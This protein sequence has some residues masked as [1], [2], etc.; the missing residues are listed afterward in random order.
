MSW[1][2]VLDVVAWLC[3]LGGSLLAFSAG[4]GVVRFPDLL[5]RMHTAA[6]PQVLGL[7]LLMLGLGLR[8]R[9][10]HIIWMLVLVVLFQMLTAPVA[11]HM[12]SRAGYRTGKVRSEMLVVDELTRDMEAAQA[13]ASR[14]EQQDEREGG[15][16]VSG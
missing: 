16:A 7:L 2:T 6:K 5:A 8:L 15:P 14:E 9:T 4:V 11:S 10:G 13:Q 12:L 3:L 1:E